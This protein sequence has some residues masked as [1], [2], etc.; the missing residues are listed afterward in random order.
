[1]DKKLQDTL[2]KE[3]PL[4]YKEH[5]WNMSQTCMCWGFELG[6]G[7]YQLIYDLS[8]KLENLIKKQMDETPCPEKTC[9]CGCNY[10]DH[11]LLT[12]NKECTKVFTMSFGFKRIWF[13]IPENIFIH[14]YRK[15][16]QKFKRAA[17]SFFEFI[18][19][20][21]HKKISCGCKKFDEMHPAA[22]QVKEKFGTLRFYMDYAT[23]EMYKLIEEAE[24]KS[25]ITCELCG[26][27]GEPRT[28][29]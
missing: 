3:F 2:Y 22:S 25:A 26:A 18:S 7:W 9:V 24:A 10:L 1:M 6:D 4:L 21:I 13:I 23:D 14:I 28:G 11:N 29:K 15:A 20:V 12:D 19:P 5:T 17:N 8:T 27:F 16:V